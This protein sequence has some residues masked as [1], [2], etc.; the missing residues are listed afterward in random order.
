V[1]HG[2]SASEQLQ[3]V[4]LGATPQAALRHLV[5]EFERRGWRDDGGGALAIVQLLQDRG[6]T[7]TVRQAASAVPSSF[8]AINRAKRR[9]LQD[10]VRA[11]ASRR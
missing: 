10:A 1:A 11:A 5:D 3:L 7:A 2:A 6:G 8:M 9:D 4:A